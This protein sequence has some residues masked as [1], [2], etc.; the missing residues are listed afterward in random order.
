MQPAQ[1]HHPF[2]GNLG[3]LNGQCCLLLRYNR[4]ENCVEWFYGSTNI[5]LRNLS[6]SLPIPHLSHQHQFGSLSRRSPSSE[7]M[8]PTK[9][10][11]CP[12]QVTQSGIFSVERTVELKCN[13]ALICKHASK[14]HSNQGRGLDQ[15]SRHGSFHWK[16]SSFWT[17]AH[18]LHFGQ[19]KG[20]QVAEHCFLCSSSC[21]G[22]SIFRPTSR[23]WGILSLTSIPLRSASSPKEVRGRVLS[24]IVTIKSIR[25][26]FEQTVESSHH[27]IEIRMERHHNQT[28]NLDKGP[29]LPP[30]ITINPSPG[31]MEPFSCLKDNAA[32][33]RRGWRPSRRGGNRSPGWEPAS[34]QTLVSLV[35][36]DFRNSKGIELHRIECH[37]I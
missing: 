20:V 4:K 29:S 28:I 26:F 36:N 33:K 3:W 27:C 19:G 21:F 5:Q 6:V 37:S 10:P 34:P 1:C 30:S 11:P 2:V 12:R 24:I 35:C 17:P 22:E 14:F 8:E 16:I 18:C 23:T 25:W 13:I 32:W 9:F 15:C 31:S 7:R